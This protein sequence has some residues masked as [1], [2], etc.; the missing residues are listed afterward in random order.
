MGKTWKNPEDHYKVR[1]FQ[2][3]TNS[4][5]R[6]AKQAYYENLGDKLSNPQT[7]QKIFWSAI[8]R[9]TNKKKHTNI[10]PIVDNN[11]YIKCL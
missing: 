2:K 5:I 7:G 4:L 9:L 3:S 11:I 10:P 6:E 1:E 8:K